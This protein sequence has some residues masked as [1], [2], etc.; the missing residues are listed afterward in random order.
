MAALN[1]P[2]TVLST[3]DGFISGFIEIPGPQSANNLTIETFADLAG[4]IPVN[5]SFPALFHV[6]QSNFSDLTDSGFRDQFST[7]LI[8][9]LD[10]IGGPQ[11]QQAIILLIRLRRLD[12]DSGW[13]QSLR[14]DVL[15][16]LVS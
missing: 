14:I 9:Y 2:M 1:I 16:K 7:Q 13:G 3:N 12:Q 4:S 5:P 8:Q 6:R 11:G 15:L 10:R